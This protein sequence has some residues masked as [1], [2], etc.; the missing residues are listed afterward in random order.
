VPSDRPCPNRSTPT[1]I[2]ASSRSIASS[3]FAVPS[4][5]SGLPLWSGLHDMG[6]SH[7]A[8]DGLYSQRVWY[9]HRAGSHEQGVVMT[10]N[11]QFHFGD[12]FAPSFWLFPWIGSNPSS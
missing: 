2:G 9:F 5:P 3:A 8:A 4:P 12:T 1:K 7:T 11:F 6:E 10:F